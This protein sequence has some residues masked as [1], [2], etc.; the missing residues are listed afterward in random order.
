MLLII[1]VSI[2]VGVSVGAAVKFAVDAK[3]DNKTSLAIVRAS[4]VVYLV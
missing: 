2:F 4:L 3:D 1:C